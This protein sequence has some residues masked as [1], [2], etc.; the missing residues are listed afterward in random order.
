MTFFFLNNFIEIDDEI[1]LML[2]PHHIREAIPKLSERIAFENKFDQYKTL[3]DNDTSKAFVPL[4]SLDQA[5][6]SSTDYE[7]NN[8]VPLCNIP[9]AG[10][11]NHCIIYQ[12]L[13]VRN[14]NDILAIQSIE[15]KIIIK[16]YSND[17]KSIDNNDRV[18]IAREII[19]HMLVMNVERT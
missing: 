16:K 2:K 18:N 10:S 11:Y 17:S 19:H 5:T 13:N 15:L 9:D 3:F 6:E 7:Y 4:V 8:I 12:N 1:F 14:R